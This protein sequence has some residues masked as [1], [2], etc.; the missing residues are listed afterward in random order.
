MCALWWPVRCVNDLGF[1]AN[2][3]NAGPMMLRSSRWSPPARM[4]ATWPHAPRSSQNTSANATGKPSKWALLLLAFGIL[5]SR[6]SN[7]KS[8]ETADSHIGRGVQLLEQSR[9]EAAAREF[10][11]A[12]ELEPH[13]RT[14]RIQLGVCNFA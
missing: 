6:P 4:A 10:G 12:L 3:A 9:F 13:S 11:A 5:V 7:G 2:T 1:S 14:A 8:A